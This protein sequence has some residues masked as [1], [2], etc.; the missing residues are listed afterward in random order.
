VALVQG[1][2]QVGQ[3]SKPD[4]AFTAR[5]LIARKD[6]LFGSQPRQPTYM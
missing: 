6:E 3:I 5:E 4:D 2:H 1:W